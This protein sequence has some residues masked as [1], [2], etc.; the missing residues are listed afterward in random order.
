MELNPGHKVVMIAGF[1]I[2][3]CVKRED[4]QT[5]QIKLTVVTELKVSVLKR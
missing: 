4:V 3:L 1:T 5:K 2:C